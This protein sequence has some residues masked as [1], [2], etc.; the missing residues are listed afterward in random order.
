MR[1]ACFTRKLANKQ[2]NAISRMIT[3][4]KEI[5]AELRDGDFWAVIEEKRIFGV[6][7]YKKLESFK[8][9]K[10]IFLGVKIKENKC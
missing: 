2:Y 5:N 10:T 1:L 8:S 6:A 3:V 9:I 4:K 7:L